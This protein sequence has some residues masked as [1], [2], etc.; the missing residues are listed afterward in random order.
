[1]NV[2]TMNLDVTKRPAIAPVLYIGQGDANGTTLVATIYDNGALLDLTD[3]SVRLAI[4]SADKASYYAVDGTV[5]GSEAT[6]PV[7]E[8]YAA[9]VAG[10][11][12]VAYVEV[13]DGSTVTCSTNRFRVV[14][15]ESAEE[16]TD[17]STAYSNGII[18]ATERAIAAAEAAEG[19]VLQDV[20]TMSATVKGGALLGSG[21]EVEDGVLSVDAE[22]IELPVM[23]AST[24]GVAKSGDGLEVD[25]SDCLNVVPATT[26]AIG[27]VILD[28]VSVTVDND[29]KLHSV[30]PTMDASTKGGAKLGDGL[31]I[32]S[33]V[34][35]VD[36]D[37]VSDGVL[38]LAHGG[39][40]KASSAA[41]RALL[42]DIPLT[43]SNTG[44]S[45]ADKETAALSGFELFAGARV[46]V[47]F[48]NANT[49]ASGSLTLNVNS[50]GAKTVYVAGSATS[51]SNKCLWSAGSICEFIYDGTYWHYIGN[52]IDGAYGLSALRDSVSP[53]ILY[54]KT[55]DETW[56]AGGTKNLGKVASYQLY[57]V[58]PE[59]GATPVF[60]S[61]SAS[62]TGFFYLR[63]GNAYDPATSDGNHATYG[64]T[65][66]V[67]DA[68]VWTY[69]GGSYIA[70]SPSTGH[71]VRHDINVGRVV[72][73]L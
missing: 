60:G 68:G 65:F 42:G 13:I 4:R 50:T 70:H 9:T 71:G 20:P 16:G 22:S 6:F 34:L 40:G 59:G 37:T 32:S 73:L 31:D 26:S 39:T 67:T 15:L 10:T 54:N 21:L 45:T 47:L 44:A 12:D 64:M 23:G 24:K 46:L 49:Y 33:D 28:G 66:T 11:T 35:S 7:D 14:V 63:C 19:V 27:G 61:P 18:E 43:T 52:N 48:S 2:Q 30:V 3:L 1:M 69:Q 62:G 8:T 17:P 51:T 41:S 57:L 58:F 72:R 38:P 53:R 36:L 25:S 29:G 56:L 5:N 55:V